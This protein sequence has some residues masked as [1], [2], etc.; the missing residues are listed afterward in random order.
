MLKRMINNAKIGLKIIPVDPLLIKS[1][2]ATVGGVDM[3]FV[4]LHK[5][6]EK[7][8]PY[9]PGSS[10]KGMI[11]AYAEK[12]CRSLRAEPV[13]VCLPYVKPRDEGERERSQASCGLRLDQCGDTPSSAQIYNVS[14]P[15]CRLFGSHKFIGRCA[16]SDAYLTEDARK[17]GG[18][19]LEI[20]NGVAIDRFTGGAAPSALYDLEVLTKGEFETVIDLRNFERWQIGLLGLVLREMEDELVRIGFGKSRGLGKIRA[21]ITEFKI[22]YFGKKP[23]GFAGLG[24]LCSEEECRAYG[25]YEGSEGG[26]LPEP[27]KEGLR[28]TSD[29]TQN[30]K[31]ILTPAVDDFVQYIEQSDWPKGINNITGRRE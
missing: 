6:G 17:K 18:H 20:R 1:G 14:C 25:F 30:W 31:E 27:E 8:E 10:L 2:Q 9:L 26:T 16:A 19:V 12:I 15:V 11:R 29:V 4:R 3:S 22:G 23:N 24:K 13:P 5:H 21:E 28:Y 7:E